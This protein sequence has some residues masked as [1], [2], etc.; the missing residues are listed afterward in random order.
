MTIGPGRTTGYFL[1][2]KKARATGCLMFGIFLVFVGW[3]IFGIALEV[4]GLLNLF[5]NMF[6]VLMVLLKQM[7]FVGTVLNGGD[8][9]SSGGWR[10][11][12]NKGNSRKANSRDRYSYDDEEEDYYGDD[13]RDD[14][15]SE[16]GG[17]Y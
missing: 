15:Y 7:P 8:S 10:N 17:Y 1:Q 3:P 13:N 12:S 4:F 16:R 14:G 11:K 6:P 5:G 2:P 9:S